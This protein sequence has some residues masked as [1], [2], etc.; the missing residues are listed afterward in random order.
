M[1]FV[2]RRPA[3]R[4]FRWVFTPSFRHWRTGKTVYPKTAKYFCFLVRA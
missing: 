4:G 2:P 1:H 3:P